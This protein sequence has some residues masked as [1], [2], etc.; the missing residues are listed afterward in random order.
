MCVGEERTIQVIL[1]SYGKN[2]GRFWEGR[3]R[4]EDWLQQIIVWN[5]SRDTKLHEWNKI[6]PK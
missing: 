6:S 3:V 1:K 5:M 4:R 2:P